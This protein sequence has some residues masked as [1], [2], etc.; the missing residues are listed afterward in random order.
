MSNSKRLVPYVTRHS[1]FDGYWS[2]VQGLLDWFEVD[3]GFTEL[4]FIQIDLCDMCVFVPYVTLAECHMWHLISY[5]DTPHFMCYTP[6]STR[7][8]APRICDTTHLCYFIFDVVCASISDVSHSYVMPHSHEWHDA[9]IYIYIHHALCIPRWYHHSRACHVIFCKRALQF[10][11]NFIFCIRGMPFSCVISSICVTWYRIAPITSHIRMKVT[12][13]YPT[14]EWYS[15]VIR[16][17][18]DP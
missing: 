16:G 12:Q 11:A 17:G 9:F 7:S 3:L 1:S 4:L 8:Y 14:L 18:E 15:H 10:V 2:T 13:S 5:F 6:E